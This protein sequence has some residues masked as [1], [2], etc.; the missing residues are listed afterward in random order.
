MQKY[1]I[2]VPLAHDIYHIGCN[3][4][5]NILRNDLLTQ[6]EQQLSTA[7]SSNFTDSSFESQVSEKLS[8][9]QLQ[10]SHKGFIPCKILLANGDQQACLSLIDSGNSVNFHACIKKS[11]ADSLN[12]QIEPRQDIQIGLASLNH[13]MNVEGITYFKMLLFINNNYFQFN[14][15]CLVLNDLTDNINIGTYFLKEFD[16]NIQFSKNA[17]IKLDFKNLGCIESVGSLSNK[18]SSKISQ[19][20]NNENKTSDNAHSQNSNIDFQTLQGKNFLLKSAKQ[21]FINKN[22]I[23]QIKCYIENAPTNHFCF[24]AQPSSHINIDIFGGILKRVKAPNSQFFEYKTLNTPI[25]LDKDETVGSVIFLDYEMSNLKDLPLIEKNEIDFSHFFQF[26][27]ENIKSP[28]DTVKNINLYDGGSATV[29]QG[30]QVK[31]EDQKRDLCPIEVQLGLD[32][33]EIL[34][35]DQKL[36]KTSNRSS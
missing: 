33:N 14:M 36:K 10:G 22:T 27:N 4:E 17:P 15:K 34:E 35:K 3:L 30:F 18:E 31:N 11:F 6:Y 32:G 24:I 5:E 21:Q 20:P 28:L 26:V 7:D 19:P 12:L 16:V 25:Q 9:K 2:L 23:G 13:N 8:I 29:K 1:P